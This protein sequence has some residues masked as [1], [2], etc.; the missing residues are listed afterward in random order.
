M[1]F[2]SLDQREIILKWLYPAKPSRYK[3]W[4]YKPTY[5]DTGWSGGHG[6]R[7]VILVGAACDRAAPQQNTLLRHIHQLLYTNYSQ[8]RFIATSREETEFTQSVAI[9]RMLQ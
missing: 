4:S 8:I 7:R 6:V 9:I 3:N 1:Y 5:T 2:S